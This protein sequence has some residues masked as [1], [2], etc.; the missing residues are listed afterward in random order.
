MSKRGIDRLI[1]FLIFAL[2]FSLSVLFI[3]IL[4]ILETKP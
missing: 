3:I 2:L 1:T 4:N